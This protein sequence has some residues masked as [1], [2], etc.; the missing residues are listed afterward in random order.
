MSRIVILVGL[1]T[2]VYTHQEA[3]ALTFK[4]METSTNVNTVFQDGDGWL[5]FGTWS[6]LR[7]FDGYSF[8][9]YAAVTGDRRSISHSIVTS[10]I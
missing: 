6:G 7:K 5:W 4:H 1:S 9:S 3:S 2:P 8:T 10:I